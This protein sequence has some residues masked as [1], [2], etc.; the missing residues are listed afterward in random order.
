MNAMRVPLVNSSKCSGSCTPEPQPLREF[1]SIVKCRASRR[2]KFPRHTVLKLYMLI[3]IDRIFD[4]RVEGGIPNF[5]A[6]AL[7][8]EL[9]GHERGA[10]TGTITQKIGRLEPH[11]GRKRIPQEIADELAE[12]HADDELTDRELEVLQQVASGNTNKIIADKIEIPK[13]PSKLT[14]GKSSASFIRRRGSR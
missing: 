8:S 13:K 1:A 7:E 6:A 14:C 9:F 11:G 12:H 4:S 3:F 10:F 2:H 5:A